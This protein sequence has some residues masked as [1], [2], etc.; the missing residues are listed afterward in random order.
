MATPTSTPRTHT[1]AAPGEYSRRTIVLSALALVL[2]LLGG[3]TLV[4]LTTDSSES[5]DQNTPAVGQERGRD[6]QASPEI[7]PRPG[8][9]RAPRNA[10][11]RGGPEQLGLFG[12]MA[13]GLLVIGVVIFRGGR[14]ARAG[15]RLWAAAAASGQD[16]AVDGRGHLTGP[17]RSPPG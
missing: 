15:R 4:A 17:D 3:A 12:L 10:A 13:A 2:V 8:S 16:G 7:I 14:Q 1:N 9:G 11:D 6:Q 5:G